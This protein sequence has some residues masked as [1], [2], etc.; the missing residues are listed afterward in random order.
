M[1]KIIDLTGQKFNRLT[2]IKYMHKKNKKHYWLC[3]C[4]C[5]NE[6]IVRSDMLKNGHTQ[7]CGCW[8]NETRKMSKNKVHG[9]S[10]TKLFYVWQGMQ[11]RCYNPNVKEFKNYGTRGITVCQEWLDDF[12]AFYNWAMANGYKKGLS[13]DRI[14]VNGNYE[15]SNCRWTDMKTQQRNRSNNHLLT[16]KDKTHCISEWSEITGISQTAIK[17][18]LYRGWSVEKAL[19][20]GVA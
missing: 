16:F 1:P 19:T 9:M 15:P 11:R 4:E 7:S 14:D 8:Y 5:G 6:I 3:K 18:R 2:A 13:I 20:T 12:M 17:N 10:K